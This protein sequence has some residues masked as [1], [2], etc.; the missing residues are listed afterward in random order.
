MPTLIVVATH[1]V[2]VARSGQRWHLSSPLEGYRFTCAVTDPHRPGRA[3]IGTANRGLWR[4]D[5]D[6]GTFERVH[7]GPG[8]GY[9]TAVRVDP[10]AHQPAGGTLY[11]GTEPSHFYRSR[12]GGAHWE[13]LAGLVAL[14][15]AKSWSFPP[16]PS[17][18]HVRWIEPD[19]VVAGRIFV[20]IEAGAL[21][22][23][24]DGGLTW[25]DR[26][27]DGPFDT[28]TMTSQRQVPGHLYAA[29][30]DGYYETT[31]AG[32]TWDSNEQGLHHAYLVGIA[33]DPGDPST[34]VISGSSG[35][36]RAYNPATAEGY[37]YWRSGKG[38]WLRVRDGLPD[39]EG[40]T[41]SHFATTG[42]PGVIYAANNRGAFFSTNA[43][44]HWRTLDLPW[45]ARY[46]S[47]GLQAL[48][49]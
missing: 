5:D 36:F 42:D 49:I 46:E 44:R 12:D 25:D 33:V 28:H 6:G 40:T 30:G 24:R 3:Y 41:V 16:K 17:T 48:L 11:L 47:E 23:T 37:V 34:M 31:D 18:H 27:P 8:S 1:R 14:P 22:R 38:K 13:E 7:D 20:A 15:S 19:P 9:I 35:P 29:A 2:L 43:G 10:F 39:P 21:V 4:T 45:D 32:L 26:V